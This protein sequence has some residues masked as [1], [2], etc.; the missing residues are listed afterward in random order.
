ML[1]KQILVWKRFDFK[2]HIIPSKS[3]Q[4]DLKGVQ[5]YVKMVSMEN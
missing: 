3:I 4:F 2:G 5:F 1:N